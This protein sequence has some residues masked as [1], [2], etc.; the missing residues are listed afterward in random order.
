MA[1]TNYVTLRY[2][3]R[4]FNNDKS[5]VHNKFY[6]E[7]DRRKTLSTRGL[8]KHMSDHQSIYSFDV[9]LGV[10]GK[11]STCIPEM[12]GTGVPVKLDGIGIFYPTLESE[13]TDT[14]AEFSNDKVKGVHMRFLPESSELDNVTSRVFKEKCSLEMANVIE[15]TGSTKENN[16]RKKFIPVA[17]WLALYEGNGPS[18]GDN[19]GGGGDNN[20]GGD[21]D[22]PIVNP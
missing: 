2:N 18:G 22:Q 4:K 8:A 7:V 20:Q 1:Q 21:D 5:K 13:P 15:V 17:D 14:V 10:L 6:A 19:Q 16:L 9:V 11:L 3:L 12:V